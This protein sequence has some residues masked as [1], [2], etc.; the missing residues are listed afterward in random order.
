MLKNYIRSDSGYLSVAL[1]LCRLLVIWPKPEWKFP[2]WTSSPSL[3][4][5][6]SPLF[7]EVWQTHTRV[8]VNSE[9]TQRVYTHI[10]M[11]MEGP[12]K[13]ES[14]FSIELVIN[15][16]TQSSWAFISRKQPARLIVIVHWADIRQRNSFAVNANDLGLLCN[17]ATAAGLYHGGLCPPNTGWTHSSGL[18]GFLMC[19]TGSL[20][21]S[22]QPLLAGLSL[23]GT[24][25]AQARHHRGISA[26]YVTSYCHAECSLHY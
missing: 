2:A 17:M 15:S 20:P 25:G 13:T 18:I 8:C 19:F 22:P 26:V 21:S 11:I 9:P 12:T 4:S 7:S 14:S 6:S 3:V 24:A 16:V 10:L 5:I 1:T 23:Y